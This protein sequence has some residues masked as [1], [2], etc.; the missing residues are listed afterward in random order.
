MYSRIGFVHEFRELNQD[1]LLFI[2]KKHL[3]KV[4]VEYDTENFNDQEAL[5]AT[6]SFE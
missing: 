6:M 2:M 4:G 5:L 3:D 1:E